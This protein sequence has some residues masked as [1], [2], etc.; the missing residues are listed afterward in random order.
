MQRL[1]RIVFAILVFALIAPAV[2][3]M[4]T[5]AADG[6]AVAAPCHCDAGC[7]ATA[8]QASGC[9]Q[10]CAVSGSGLALAQAGLSFNAANSVQRV[11]FASSLAHGLVWPPP[12]QPPTT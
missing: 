3:T 4:P 10:A 6:P 8:C 5:F 7:D 11:P 9:A 2:G 12:L 1:R